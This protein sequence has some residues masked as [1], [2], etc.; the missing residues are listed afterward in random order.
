MDTRVI[1]T[2]FVKWDIPELDT[3]KDSKVYKLRLKLNNG[4][5]LNRVEKNWITENVIN[6]NYFNYGIALSG[7]CFDFSDVLKTFVI[8]QYGSYRE[9]KA[10]DRTSLRACIYGKIDKIIEL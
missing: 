9:Y 8:K 7:Y 4:E 6:C 5:C 10:C 1:V 2:K 3:L